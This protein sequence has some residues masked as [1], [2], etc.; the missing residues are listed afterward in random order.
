MY[1]TVMYLRIPQQWQTDPQTVSVI[2][3]V[4]GKVICQEPSYK[5]KVGLSRAIWDPE[6]SRTC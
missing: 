5:N 6:I 4:Y 2:Y 1:L 3:F